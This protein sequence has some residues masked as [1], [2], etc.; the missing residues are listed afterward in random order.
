MWLKTE[1]EKKHIYVNRLLLVL[2]CY[3]FGILIVTFVTSLDR[4]HYSQIIR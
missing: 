1:S 3:G 4:A 2:V